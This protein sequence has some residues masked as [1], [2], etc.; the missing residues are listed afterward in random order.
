MTLW[1][2]LTVISGLAPFFVGISNGTHHG[3]I[4]V[5][6]GGIIGLAIGVI[7]LLLARKAGRFIFT[8][9]FRAEKK[10]PVFIACVMG[11]VYLTLIGWVFASTFAV[12]RVMDIWKVVWAIK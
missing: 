5:I 4:G 9:L 10:R 12:T 8:R 1:D 3:L 11:V 7:A 6:T 2:L